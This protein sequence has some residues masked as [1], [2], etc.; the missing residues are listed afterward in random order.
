MDNQDREWIRELLWEWS[1]YWRTERP[2]G[3]VVGYVGTVDF[4]SSG[5]GRA[6]AGEWTEQDERMRRI[7]QA[8][9][10]LPDHL[11]EIIKQRY[12][13]R[14]EWVEVARRLRIGL[15]TAKRFEQ[16]SVD[17]LI[18]YFKKDG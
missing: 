14:C 17:S 6:T 5:G 13:F 3:L 18:D 2:G 12:Q 15:R 7:T 1:D 10:S 9:G 11:R 8:V 16:Q 4:D